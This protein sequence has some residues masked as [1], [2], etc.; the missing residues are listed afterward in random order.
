MLCIRSVE[1]Y[2]TAQVGVFGTAL[3]SMPSGCFSS[4]CCRSWPTVKPNTDDNISHKKKKKLCIR[5]NQLTRRVW[6]DEEI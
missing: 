2:E 4:L 5:T 3:W 1:S 6:V